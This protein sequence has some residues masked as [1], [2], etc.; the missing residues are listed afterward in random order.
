LLEAL[1]GKDRAVLQ[2]AMDMKKGET[3]DF[4]DSYALLFTWCRD[5]L[6]SV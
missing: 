2:R 4:A 3:F 6:Q 5:T 1:E